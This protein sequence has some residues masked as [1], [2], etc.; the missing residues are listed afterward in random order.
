MD[1]DKDVGPITYT[2]YTLVGYS[3]SQT[4]KVEEILEHQPVTVLIDTSSTNN[5]MDSKV[6]D[7]LAYHIEDCDKFEV[8]IADGRTLTCDRKCLKIKLIIEGQK[9]LV[10]FFLLPLEDFEVV[11]GIEWL[12]TLGD[13]SWNFFNFLNQ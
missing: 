10:D 4:M 8:M 3:N 1:S 2:M 13:I 7:R 9:L 5:F 11:F 12:S 6:A